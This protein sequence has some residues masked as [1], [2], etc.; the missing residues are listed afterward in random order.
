MK[1]L[2]AMEGYDDF[3][4]TGVPGPNNGGPDP[5]PSR[6]ETPRAAQTAQIIKERGLSQ[7]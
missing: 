1:K 7:F 6:P 5:N 3:V 4:D 2:V